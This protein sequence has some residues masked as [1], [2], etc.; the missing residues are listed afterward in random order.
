[1]CRV[2][3]KSGDDLRLE[4]FA[5]QLISLMDQIFR[6]KNLKL[7]LKPYEI[8]ATNENV[9]IIEFIQDGLG[10]DY[11]RKTMSAKLNRNCDLCDYFRKNFGYPSRN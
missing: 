2:I 11:I 8:L 4:Q 9:G 5:M 6:R 7:W 10:L 3:V 1:M